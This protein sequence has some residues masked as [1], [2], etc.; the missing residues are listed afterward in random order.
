MHTVATSSLDR[1]VKT[2]WS[3][4]T[5]INIFRWYRAAWGRYTQPSG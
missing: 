4:C 1:Y 3:P 5:D 2:V